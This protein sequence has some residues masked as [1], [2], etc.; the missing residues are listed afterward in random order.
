MPHL[1]CYSNTTL[2]VSE[3]P[4]MSVPTRESIY[5]LIP[6]PPPRVVRP[7]RHKSKFS[8]SVREE[9]RHLKSNA[10][11]LVSCSGEIQITVA[12][13]HLQFVFHFSSSFSFRVQQRFLQTNQLIISRS[14]QRSR[15]CLKTQLSST[16][17]RRNLMFLLTQNSR[18]WLA[19]PP[20]TSS[21]PT[22]SLTL[23]QSPRNQ[24]LG[25]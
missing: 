17:V 11:T 5:C 3:V 13:V 7:P 14:T 24:F 23:P 9:T 20:R 10:K 19:S 12:I 22:P 16:L 4:I 25:M 6:P 21:Q 2:S 1:C 8:D 15:S 18:S